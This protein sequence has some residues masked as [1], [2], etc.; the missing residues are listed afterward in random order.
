VALPRKLT[1]AKLM[2]AELDALIKSY[3]AKVNPALAEYS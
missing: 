3:L 1:L 2:D